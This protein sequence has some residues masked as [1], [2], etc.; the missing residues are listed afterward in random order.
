M[1]P[2]LY[3]V[4]EAF[5]TQKVTHSMETAWKIRPLWQV[6]LEGLAER[7]AADGLD[8][9]ALEEA[10]LQHLMRHCAIFV[11][12]QEGIGPVGYAEI[13]WQSQ[14]SALWRRQIAEIITLRVTED[15]RCQGIGR[16]LL[17]ACE[18]AAQRANRQRLGVYQPASAEARPFFERCGYVPADWDAEGAWLLSSPS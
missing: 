10:Y 8:F 12:I 17:G 16:A 15:Q 18:A 4:L 2:P 9:P 7:F 1:A 6:D 14:Q 11:A 5:A 13:I 3:T